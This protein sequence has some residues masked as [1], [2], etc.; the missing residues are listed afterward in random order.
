MSSPDISSLSTNLSLF[1]EESE[2]RAECDK[3]NHGDESTAAS[4]KSSST[5]PSADST[6]KAPPKHLLTVWDYHANYGGELYT[7]R[8]EGELLMEL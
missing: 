8:W 2:A 7:V 5:K 6:G 3:S 4:T 1:S